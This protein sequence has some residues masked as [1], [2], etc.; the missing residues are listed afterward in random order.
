MVASGQPWPL[1]PGESAPATHWIRGWVGPRTGMDAVEYRKTLRLPEN[2]TPAVQPEAR[3]YTAWAVPIPTRHFIRATVFRGSVV[4]ISDAHNC[5]WHYEGKL[6][7]YWK[8]SNFMLSGGSVVSSISNFNI[9]T[10]NLYI[11][12]LGLL[13]KLVASC[14]AW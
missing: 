7:A 4:S 13:E 9:D 6:L 3:C 1:S 12:R 11:A 5:I 2:R 14:G 8:L 10:E